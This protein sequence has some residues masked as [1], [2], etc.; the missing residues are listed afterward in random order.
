MKQY[1]V[2][3]LANAMMIGVAAR[4]AEA[5]VSIG[6]KSMTRQPVDW[7]SIRASWLEQLLLHRA[8]CTAGG[9][10]FQNGRQCLGDFKRPGTATVA[11]IDLQAAHVT[12]VSGKA[13]CDYGDRIRFRPAGGSQHGPSRHG[14]RNNLPYAQLDASQGWADPNNTG[15]L[16]NGTAVGPRWLRFHVTER[17][18]HRQ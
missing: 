1:R 12:H 18:Q 2:A 11:Q 9:F 13:I 17:Q 16:V 3:L 4:P 10:T 8:V 5:V 14:Q 7:T 15:A 6:C